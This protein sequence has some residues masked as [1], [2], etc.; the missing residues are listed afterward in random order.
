MKNL[1]G[2]GMSIVFLGLIGL[3]SAQAQETDGSLPPA[4]SG[5]SLNYPAGTRIYPSG[6]IVP[7]RGKVQF[8]S[9]TIRHGDGSTTFYYPNGTRVTTP[10]KTIAPSGTFLTP[11]INGGL[12]NDPLRQSR[13][14]RF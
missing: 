10:G 8:P 14:N 2:Y 12:R 6:T 5:N 13:P 4:G 11:G 9:N 7:V 1:I 3:G